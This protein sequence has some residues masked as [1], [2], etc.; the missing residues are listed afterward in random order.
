MASSKTDLFMHEQLLLLA[1]R[2]KQGTVESKAAMHAFALGGAILAELVLAGR[3]QIDEDK[4]QLVGLADGSPLE[5]PILD[6]ALSLI[7]AAKRRRR[8]SDWVFRLANLK[9][10]RH[11][12]AAQLCQRGILQDSQDKILLIFTRKLYPEIDPQP[13]QQLVEQLR[14][15]IFEE[16]EEVA[17]RTAIVL[18]LAHV[19]G[20]LGIHF[21]RKE[22]KQRKQRIERV[23]SEEALG[24]ATKAAVDSAQAA[25]FA[26]MAGGAAAAS[27]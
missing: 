2:E 25:M 14:Q 8:A 15:A 23:T 3:I 12:I 11:R 17:S 9:E 18:A 19:T 4:K 24:A 26:M 10:L 6:E 21:N 20:M 5:E 1:L 7:A 22:L 27:G 16:H 13:E